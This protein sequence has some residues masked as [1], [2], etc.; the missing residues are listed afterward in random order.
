MAYIWMEK[1]TSMRKIKVYRDEKGMYVAADELQR[2]LRGING[3]PRWIF[4]V[5]FSNKIYVNRNLIEQLNELYKNRR[6]S[7]V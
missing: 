2:R 3:V 6:Q 5:F 1:N 7:N 4:S